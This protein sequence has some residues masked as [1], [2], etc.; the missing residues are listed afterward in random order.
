MRTFKRILLV[1]GCLL[2]VA[3]IPFAVNRYRTARLAT[4]IEE[5]G[6]DR[7][8]VPRLGFRDYKGVIHVHSFIGG[9]STGTFEELIGA[10]NQNGLDF[11][12]M[13]EHVA[14]DFDSAAKTLNERHGRAIWIGGNEV[15]TSDGDKFLVLDGF[16]DLSTLQFN[17][18]DEL[19]GETEGKRK[20]ALVTYPES[21]RSWDADFDGIEV[22]SLHTNAKAMNPFLFLMDAV[23]S[24]GSYPELTMAR[25]FRRPAE[26]LDR[27]DKISGTRKISLF[28]GNDAHSNIGFHLFGDDANN[29]LFEIKY[30]RYGM[31]FRLMRTHVLIPENEELSR[32]TVLE[33]LRRGR[34]FLGFDILGDSSGFTFHAENAEGAR[35]VGTDSDVDAGSVLRVASPLPAKI[36]IFRNGDRVFESESVRSVEFKAREPGVYRVE[37]FLD[38]LGAPFDEMPW[39]ITNPIYVGN[40]PALSAGVPKPTNQN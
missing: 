6:K 10:A 17:S 3:Q 24:F 37:A 19:L 36:V 7:G 12:V 35:L 40:P 25:H 39:V 28:G 2:L 23:W 38:S 34:S 11:V 32:V 33:A 9:H 22:F 16:S 27:F 31:I 26:N 29:K 20:L 1:A 13:T 5:L 8:P 21:F 4:E 15:P 18:T 30:D 14:N